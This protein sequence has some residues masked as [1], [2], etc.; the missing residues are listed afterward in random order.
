[1][2]G[3]NSLD[4]GVGVAVGSLVAVAVGVPVAVLVG[5]AV[6][7]AGVAVIVEYSAVPVVLVGVLRVA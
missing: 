7:V 6:L 5:V 3:K 1:M 2:Y 4:F